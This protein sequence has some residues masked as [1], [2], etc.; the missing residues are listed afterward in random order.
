MVKWQF[1]PISSRNGESINEMNEKARTT[2]ITMCRKALPFT[3]TLI[4]TEDDKHR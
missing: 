3:H 1:N 4:D 2:M